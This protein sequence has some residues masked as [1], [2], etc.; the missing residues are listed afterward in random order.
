MKPLLTIRNRIETFYNRHGMICSYVLRLLLSFL[1]LL[2][3]RERIG[4]NTLLSQIWFIIAFSFVSAFVKVRF[5]VLVMGGYTVLQ[6]ATL[7]IGVGLSVLLIM[8]AIYLL[9]LRLDERF[10][11]VLLLIPLLGIL[12]LQVLIPLVLGVIA[13]AGSVGV[14][15]CGSLIAYILRY[16]STNAAVITGFKDAGE[17]A[18]ANAFVNGLFAYKELFY[19]TLILVLVF[20]TVYNIRKINYKRANDMAVAVGAGLNIILMLL[21][22]ILFNT[23]SYTRLRYILIGTAVSFVL[24]LAAEN[25]IRP[26]DFTRTE[27]L[28]FEDEEFYYY[29]KAVPKVT[30]DKETVSVTRISSRKNAQPLN[31]AEEVSTAEPKE[32]HEEPAAE[33][34]DGLN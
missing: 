12:R 14:I 11:F 25:L 32:A 21:A 2:G 1:V 33:G 20:F 7:S 5:L 16:V 8:A 3:V 22:N 4:Y 31:F 19:V 13:P 26:L 10:G 18:T 30:L 24:A 9:Y 15:I 17:F 34:K 28:E 27:E 29:V 6:I 23:M